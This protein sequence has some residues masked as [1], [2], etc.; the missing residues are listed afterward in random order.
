VKIKDIQTIPIT[1]VKDDPNWKTAL[2]ASPIGH[3]TVVKINSDKNI[4]GIGFAGANKP[5]DGVEPEI[6]KVVFDQYVR[7]LAGRDPFDI[8]KIINELDEIPPSEISAGNPV[9][10]LNAG[11]S[12]RSSIDIA[13]HDLKA[14]AAGWPVYQLLGGMVREEVPILRMIGIK[15]P[16]EMA[17]NALRLTKEGYK[18]VKIKLEGNP[19]KD[20][21]RVRAVREAVGP[22]IHL[23]TDPNQSYSA[24]GAIAAIRS[25]KPY[26]IEMA[27]Q[28]VP[29]N[30]FAGMVKVSRNVD[31]LIEAHECAKTADNVFRLM[32]DGFTGFVS[33]GVTHGG[34]RETR[35]VADV[36]KLGNV[37]CLLACVGSSILSAASLHLAAA[38]TNIS[39]ACQIAEFGRFV[40]DPASGIVVDHGIMRVPTRPGLGI[41]LSI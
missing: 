16:A 9:D 14:K 11:I 34:L 5:Y 7:R 19:D 27:E 37:K 15:E 2:S 3:G 41:E 20:L 25:W 12:A 18:Y 35:R 8:E 31:C 1:M 17:Q 39:Y 40:N 23:T 22:A 38:T 4:T 13:L 30:D 36:C 33:L 32:K 10:I 29:E 21:A 26:D 6:L 28:P 24:E